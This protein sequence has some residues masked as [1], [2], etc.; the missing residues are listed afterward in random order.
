T[1][2]FVETIAKENQLLRDEIKRLRAELEYHSNRAQKAEDTLQTLESHLKAINTNAQETFNIQLVTLQNQIQQLTQEKEAQAQEFAIQKARIE[3]SFRDRVDALNTE[4]VQKVFNAKQNESSS[5]ATMKNEN[6]LKLSRGSSAIIRDIV[7]EGANAT[8]GDAQIMS[9]ILKQAKNF[10]KRQ[11]GEQNYNYRSSKL[12][13][14]MRATRAAI[15]ATALKSPEPSFQMLLNSYTTNGSNN[16]VE[17]EEIIRKKPESGLND[18]IQALCDT[19]DPA[20]QLIIE[21][22]HTIVTDVW[23]RIRKECAQS[24]AKNIAP[25]LPLPLFEAILNDAL[26]LCKSDTAEWKSL[27]GGFYLIAQL[28][29][30]IEKNDKNSNYTIKKSKVAMDHLPSRVLSELKPAVYSAMKN[31]QL[32]VREHATAALTNYIAISDS[33]TQIGTFQ[34]VI[35]KLNLHSPDEVLPAAHAEGLLDVAAQLVPHIPITFLT[36]HWHVVFP[37]CE[38][39]VMHLASTVR[40]KS[41]H[42]ICALAY[43]SISKHS[44][45]SIS[46]LQSILTSVAT[47][48]Q[49]HPDVHQRDFFWQRMEGRLMSLDGLITILGINVLDT[50]VNQIDFTP[51]KASLQV[52]IL[53]WAFVYLEKFH[54]V[55]SEAADQVWL[56][57]SVNPWLYSYAHDMSNISSW[58]TEGKSSPQPSLVQ[59]IQKGINIPMLWNSWIQHTYE[60]FQSSQYELKRM[61][62]QTLPGLIRLSL[63]IDQ[64]ALFVTW[65]NDKQDTIDLRFICIAL[66]AFLLHTRYLQE[67][68]H[69]T[70]APM[71]LEMTEKTELCIRDF[72]PIFLQSIAEI[73]DKPTILSFVQVGILYA[74]Q[75][76]SI[77]SEFI[78]NLLIFVAK[79]CALGDEKNGKDASLDRSMSS[80]IVRF[81]PVLV[82]TLPIKELSHLFDQFISIACSWLQPEDTELRWIVVD[83]CRTRNEKKTWSNSTLQLTTSTIVAL[84]PCTFLGR[85]HHCKIYQLVELILPQLCHDQSLICIE[86]MLTVFSPL[87]KSNS[88][89][90]KLI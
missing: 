88:A 17:L 26:T 49:V 30:A 8:T 46:F 64:P 22:I 87:T 77:S 25:V 51:T 89:S 2:S 78:S 72:L 39:Y 37:T 10:S 84:C 47:P 59:E 42:L 4:Y 13:L 56:K 20:I 45:T 28:L 7:T 24:I 70:E 18:L 31:D 85:V 15:E 79:N 57:Q 50:F 60:C 83:I 34:E 19:E 11:V 29:S 52:A 86:T 12:I 6:P 69:R 3:Q 55:C 82:Q 35:S 71:L 16:I 62:I 75:S 48:C 74:I 40:Q 36:K 38:K 61:A 14:S 68:V 27:D 21:C 44:D 81:L 1:T 23:S 43:L 53:K 58:P 76:K 90:K 5:D 54:V 73:D 63:W 41:S 66:Q 67:I 33:F 32:S 65:M 9:A 80:T